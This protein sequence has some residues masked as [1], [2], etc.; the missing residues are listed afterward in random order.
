MRIV[1]I[2]LT[3]PS[4]NATI[5]SPKKSMEI[6]YRKYTFIV[7]FAIYDQIARKPASAVVIY[8]IVYTYV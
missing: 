1:F 2:I 3:I 8:T 7:Y 5:P 4:N 6:Y